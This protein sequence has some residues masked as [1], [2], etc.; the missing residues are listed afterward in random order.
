[1]PTWHIMMVFQVPRGAEITG[2][3]VDAMLDARP[4]FA[5]VSSLADNQLEFTADVDSDSSDELY[6]KV[7]RRAAEVS[8]DVLG[9]PVEFIRGEVV[10]YDH[11]LDQIDPNG[12]I[13]NWATST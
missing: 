9:F 5:S 1:M 3:A 2:E 8:T 7:Y 13:R 4:E 11:W 10:R 6:A 12:G